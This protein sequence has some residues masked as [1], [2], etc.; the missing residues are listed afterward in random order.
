[1]A[2]VVVYGDLNCPFCYGLDEVLRAE[3]WVDQVD[4][5]GVQHV[6][7]API[8]WAQP[9]PLVRAMIES[10]VETVC[11]RL[12]SLSI[13]CPPAV[14]NTAY[15]ILMVAR[16]IARSRPAGDRLRARIQNALFQSGVDISE[17][18][19]IDA[20]VREVGCDLAPVTSALTGR[21]ASWQETWSAVPARMIPTIVRA[22]G[23]VRR[24]LGDP[25]GVVPFLLG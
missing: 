6:P 24:G 20:M 21:I 1:M 2:D 5:R 16:A 19:R 23:A 3:G 14:P 11:T 25:A 12:P 10:E 18:S 17:E 9:T 22:D 15:A 4:W 13:S 8:P 7:E